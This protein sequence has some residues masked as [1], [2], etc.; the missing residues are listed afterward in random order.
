MVDVTS[1]TVN[2]CQMGVAN[3][4]DHPPRQPPAPLG[5]PPLGVGAQSTRPRPAR[6][7][8]KLVLQSSLPSPMSLILQAYEPRSCTLA[9]YFP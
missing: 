2:I 1:V 3:V 9:R 8:D 6:S 7:L 5:V 4:S